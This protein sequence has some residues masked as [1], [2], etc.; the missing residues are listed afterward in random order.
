MPELPPV[1]RHYFDAK[2]RQDVDGMMAAFADAATVR[3]EG[4]EHRGAPAIRGW[5]S[6]TTRKY[7][8]TAKPT[9]VQRQGEAVVVASIVT[10]DFPG[11][12]AELRY[13]FTLAGDR[14]ASLS[15]G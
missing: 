14:I 13:R 9:T 7:R 3:D 15:V 10:G 5:M 11:S 2:N 8:V 1:I 12:P 6:E 4:E